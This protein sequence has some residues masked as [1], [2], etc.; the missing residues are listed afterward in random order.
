MNL[1]TQRVFDRLLG[2]PLCAL[3][4]IVDR[5]LPRRAVGPPCAIL[6]LLL[7]EA[8][9]AACAQPMLRELR[10]RYPSAALYMMVFE[11]NRGFA[12]LLG[13]APAQLISV[14]DRSLW[15]FMWGSWRAI[16]RLR[17]ARIDTVI[18]CELFARISALYSYLCG[19]RTRVGFHRHTQEGLYRGSFINRP[20]LY[21]PHT[22]IALQYLTLAAAIESHTSPLAKEFTLPERPELAPLEFDA[23]ALSVARERLHADFP[24]LRARRLVLIHPTG[25]LLPVR[26][27]PLQHFQELAATLINEGCAIG[28][29]GLVDDRELGQ[30]IVKHCASPYCVDLT[31]Y[32]AT[33]RD[34]LLIFHRASLLISNDGGPVHFAALT[35]VPILA[36]FGPET[37]LLYGP[38]SR[39]AICLFRRLPCAPCLSAYNHRRTPCDGDNRCLKEISVAE[40]LTAARQLLGAAVPS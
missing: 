29:I 1:G 16:S 21:N 4:S 5:L 2:V 12:E 27:W 32:T 26:A 33:I 7:A 40:A 38:L 25:G 24:A 17:A 15:T 14:S 10:M 30:S 36:F 39:R 19:A 37:P 3:L 9:A 34:L 13:L 31:G 35:P 23:S 18:D 22:H 28:V 20:V 6:V 11:R 8:G